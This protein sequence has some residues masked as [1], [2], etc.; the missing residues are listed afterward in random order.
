MS[1][2][3]LGLH[4]GRNLSV[5]VQGPGETGAR[6]ER[7]LEEGGLF[8]SPGALRNGSL[9]QMRCLKQSGFPNANQSGCHRHM[10]GVFLQDLRS[11]LY[12]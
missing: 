11:R 5:C 9:H 3:W 4:R 7:T 2:S 1:G 6:Q 12:S 10:T 8:T